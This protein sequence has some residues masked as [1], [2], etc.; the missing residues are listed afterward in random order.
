MTKKCKGIIYLVVLVFSM[1]LLCGCM[2]DYESTSTETTEIETEDN[3]IAAPIASMDC[4]GMYYEDV[5]ASF[6][7]A[8][9]VNVVAVPTEMEAEGSLRED[10]E[11]ISVFVAD[12]GDF[13]AGDP[14]DKNAEITIGYAALINST[15]AGYYVESMTGTMFAT[16]TVN[17]R[18]LPD[19]A[20]DKV[21]S[22]SE[23][24]EIEITGLVDNGWY[25]VNYN[26]TEAYVHGNYLN[27]EQQ[28]MVAAVSAEKSMPDPVPETVVQPVA[29]TPI[30]E[31]PIE[32]SDAVETPSSSGGNSGSGDSVVVPGYEDTEGNL[33]WVPVNGGK[34][35]HSYAG[36]SGMENPMQV[37]LEHAEAN[38]YTPCK[39]CH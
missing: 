28:E 14:I 34:K 23:N 8:G 21:G 24:Q 11:V 27:S 33:V 32:P 36:C 5:M 6:E 25:R 12:T 3:N 16:T 26:G 2:E 37:T 15:V 31:T 30:V 20:S 4:E 19:K 17:V 13:S 18:A 29:E 10:G 1:S 22:L 38:G 9:F 35:Y 39:R 7:E